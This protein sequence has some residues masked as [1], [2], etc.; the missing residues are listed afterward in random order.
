MNNLQKRS[1][2]KKDRLYVLEDSVKLCFGKILSQLEAASSVPPRIET[3]AR[4]RF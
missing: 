2:T 3:F 4:C 1:E